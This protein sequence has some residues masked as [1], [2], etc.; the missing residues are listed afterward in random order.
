MRGAILCAVEMQMAMKE[1]REK[2]RAQDLPEIFIGIG[3]STGTV[4]AGLI[5]SRVYRA[6]Q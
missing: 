4:M 1:L 5:G 2:D 3:V 6:S